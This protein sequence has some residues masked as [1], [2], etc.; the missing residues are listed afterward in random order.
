MSQLL[1]Q[2]YRIPFFSKRNLDRTTV[3]F[4]SL[5]KMLRLFL[6]THETEGVQMVHAFR[7]LVWGVFFTL[8]GS[9]SYALAP[10]VYQWMSPAPVWVWGGISIIIS[11]FRLISVLRYLRA[12]EICFYSSRHPERISAHICCY[13]ATYAS[14]IFQFTLALGFLITLRQL[15]TWTAYYLFGVLVDIWCL[16]RLTPS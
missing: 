14:L 8:G 1:S 11:V 10:R 9:A 16:R 15:T 7:S 3:F 13:W 12:K 5:F 4:L 2:L 6:E